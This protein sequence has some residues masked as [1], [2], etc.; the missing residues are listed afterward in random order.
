MIE[1]EQVVG[2]LATDVLNLV[3]S[4]GAAYFTMVRHLGRKLK[5]GQIQIIG[6]EI[7]AGPNGHEAPYA[8]IRFRDAE[9][10]H[11]F[12]PSAKA[13][14]S[15]PQVDVRAFLRIVGVHRCLNEGGLQTAML[16][17]LLASGVRRA[18]LFK[19]VL[20]GASQRGQTVITQE[21]KETANDLGEAKLV[22]IDF[23]LIYT[24][25]AGE[26]SCEFECH[27]C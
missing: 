21:T 1:T 11:A 20:I 6:T 16:A 12:T 8:Y 27:G 17:A 25:S 9:K 26:T 14:T 19:V 7:Y 18:N 4:G 10:E 13:Y 2:L 5:D 15:E 24:V 3:K 22:A 23:D